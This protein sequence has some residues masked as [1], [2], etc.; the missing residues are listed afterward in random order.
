MKEDLIALGDEELTLQSLAD[1]FFSA[2][3]LIQGNQEIQQP[4]QVM[5]EILCKI[6]LH[7]LNPQRLITQGASDEYIWATSGPS[8]KE[9]RLR[10]SRGFQQA[11]LRLASISE[12]YSSLVEKILEAMKAYKYGNS[13]RVA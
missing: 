3:V 10:I 7:N 6:G 9:H 12:H 5:A 2:W 4:Q 13:P 8:L 1:A 11:E